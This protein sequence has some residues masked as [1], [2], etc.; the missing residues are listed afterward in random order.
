[1]RLHESDGKDRQNVSPEPKPKGFS[2]NG[3]LE[4]S[5]WRISWVQHPNS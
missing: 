3:P 2:A 5:P 1:M 4:S